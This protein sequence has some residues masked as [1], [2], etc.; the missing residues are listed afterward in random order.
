MAKGKEFK[1]QVHH[2]NLISNWDKVIDI[3]YK[4]ILCNHQYLETI[5]LDCHNKI[6]EVKNEQHKT[7]TKG[8]RKE[9]K[10]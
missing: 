2:K 10:V 3:I 9:S 8:T 5:C 1:V 6:H 4:E 7:K